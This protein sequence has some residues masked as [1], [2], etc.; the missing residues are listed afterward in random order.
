MSALNNLH[1][2]KSTIRTWGSQAIQ[3]EALGLK[4][5][6]LS[7]GEDFEEAVL[8]LLKCEGRVV[9]AGMGKSG[10]IGKKIVATLA[11]TG[12]PSMFVHPAEASHGDLGMIGKQDVLI[13]ISKS[14][15][16]P[17]LADVLAY[18]RR[19]GISII[20][21]TANANSS[22]SKNANHLLLLPLVE[23]ACPLG[24]APT[25]STTMTLALG[26]ALALACLQGRNFQPAQ[27]REFHPG[28]Q[29]GQRLTRVRDVMHT[30]EQIP[31]VN[32]RVGLASAV[33][34]MSK[35][36]FGCVGILDDEG[37]LVGIFTDGDLRRHFSAA[38]F[39]RP[40]TELMHV[41]PHRISPD[42]LIADVAHLFTE[43]RIASVF[44]CINDQ[45]VGIIH[46]HDLLQKGFV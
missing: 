32:A 30:Y 38:N 13:A 1:L 34:E 3:K 5:L 28:G 31:L 25:T 20:A 42:S 23:E 37:K 10:H 12:T 16:S 14:G 27:F 19:F 17:E 24:L 40:I 21:I 33:L 11:S 43:K 41:N 6:A 2:E 7:L 46:V 44:A 26:D 8:T 36:R 9:V 39:D 22:L 15:E 29:L 4:Q 35:G 18:C 45:P